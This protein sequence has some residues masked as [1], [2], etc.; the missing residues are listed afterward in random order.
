MMLNYEILLGIALLLPQTLALLRVPVGPH[1]DYKRLAKK[2]SFD[3]D[4]SVQTYIIPGT[5][6][7]F[8][9]EHEKVFVSF[10]TGSYTSYVQDSSI[11]D[12]GFDANKS[13]SLISLDKDYSVNYADGTSFKGTWVMDDVSFDEDNTHTA[14]FTFGL[15]DDA[16]D[17]TN[18]FGLGYYPDSPD[19]TFID[20]LY[21]QEIISKRIFSV[22]QNTISDG[23][24]TFGGI[25]T[26]KFTGDLT[27]IPVIDSQ[28]WNVK[29]F[30]LFHGCET[31]TNGNTYPLLIDTGSSTGLYLPEAIYNKL[32]NKL[33]AQYESKLEGYIFDCLKAESLTLDFGGIQVEIPTSSFVQGVTGTDYCTVNWRVSSQSSFQLGWTFFS[34]FY[35]VFDADNKEVLIG[36]PVRN[37]EGSSPVEVSDSVPSSVQAS[38]Y[39]QTDIASTNSIDYTT[40]STV[41]IF[42]SSSSLGD[43]YNGATGLTTCTASSTSSSASSSASSS[44]SSISSSIASSSSVAESSS[45]AI[46]SVAESSTS[47]SSASVSSASNSSAPTSSA[48]QSSSESSTEPSA[49]SSWTPESSQ[50]SSAS[51][52][53][54]TIVPS[55]TAPASAS[56]STS[57][58]S[59]SFAGYFNSSSSAPVV[60]ESSSALPSSTATPSINGSFVDG[61]PV[62][63]IYIPGALGPWSLVEISSANEAEFTYSNIQLLVNGSNVSPSVFQQNGNS[64]QYNYDDE[65]SDDEMLQAHIVAAPF[66]GQ[67][68]T[69]DLV[70]AITDRSGAKLVKRATTTFTLSS[71]ITASAS[72]SS[73]LSASSSSSS[74]VVGSASSSLIESTPVPS[75]SSFAT[76]SISAAPTSADTSASGATAGDLSTSVVIVESDQT[77]IATI[78]SCSDQVCTEQ[79]TTVLVQTVTQTIGNIINIYTTYCP[80]SSESSESSAAAVT[81][82]NPVASTPTDTTPATASQAST[83]SVA[84][85]STTSIEE[86]SETSPQSQTT[87]TEYNAPSDSEGVESTSTQVIQV[88]STLPNGEVTTFASTSETSPT[89]SVQPVS[90]GSALV[91]TQ[92]VPA[93]TS[94]DSTLYM[95][96]LVTQTTYPASG[97][98]SSIPTI[99]TQGA[100]SINGTNSQSPVQVS[101][102]EGSGNRL[103]AGLLSALP[104]ALMFF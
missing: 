14:N 87:A 56:D 53:F 72:S 31:L 97:I 10:D 11:S 47:S 61:A 25:D 67:S 88:T 62:W 71:T 30:D 80:L 44:S 94:G 99:L 29:L 1:G 102:Y 57:V 26:A 91:S 28:S 40:A 15:V 82:T 73:A 8:G 36:E 46:S 81:S 4:T 23:E 90:S 33:E 86:Q 78:T 59:S 83:T 3:V 95:T 58:L 18:I 22:Y 43:Y 24:F 60:S 54:S 103:V 98:S 27:A 101:Q 70:I 12:N 37:A 35:F 84:I 45:S 64:F 2:D 55:V 66:S 9:S 89:A 76:S 51:S 69:I 93:S 7:Y 49:E 20:T 85:G 50:I 16:A 74:S 6:F 77:T 42:Q 104:I 32:I 100:T 17:S 92:L 52:Q 34:N 19:A 96:Q 79:P 48:P 63:D 68:A 65:I 39:S 38:S 21:K 75:S 41:S 5:N 13:T